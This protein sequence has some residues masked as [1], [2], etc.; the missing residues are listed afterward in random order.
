MELKAQFEQAAEDVM[1]LS[2]TP[3]NNSK[4]QLYA[5]YKQATTGDVTGKRP[6]MFDMVNRAKFDAWSDLSGT[7]QEDAMQNYVEL[8]SQ[9]KQKSS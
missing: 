5:L 1:G 3:D 2:Y 6:G 4:L 9:L 8:V 7:S